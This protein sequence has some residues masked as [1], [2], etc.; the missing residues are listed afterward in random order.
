MERRKLIL[1]GLVVGLLGAALVMFGNPKNMGVCVVCFVRDIA[2]SFGL[3]RAAVVMR[4]RL[5]V[6]GFILGAFLA[7]LV[8]RE[9]KPRGG[10]SP[11]L[12]FFMG[13]MV[14]IAAL[15]FLGCPLRMVLRLA[16]GDLNALVALA[17]FTVGI[18]L[19]IYFLRRGFTL[20]RS[21]AQTRVAAYAAPASAIGIILLA[22]IG[23][24]FLLIS[25]SGPGASAAPLLIALGAGLLVGLVAQRTRLCMVGGIRDIILFRDTQLISG[26][27]GVFL[28]ALVLNIATGSFSLGFLDQPVAHNNH[29]YNFFGMAVVGLGASLLGGC[30]L[31]QF[32]LAGEGD[33]DA[34]T[35]CLGLTVGAA[36]AHNWGLA[37]SP[38]GVPDNGRIAGWI[39]LGIFLLIGWGALE[40]IKTTRVTTSSKEVKM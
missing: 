29:F 12:R 23:P 7:S 13:A 11:V 15:L 28:A 25:E 32:I 31:R 24:A 37:A 14:S 33:V 27:I 1:A 35:T 9:F 40:T 19:G 21:Y 26:F 22:V 39:I 10:S 5:E 36:I 38:A 4:L 30:P 16:N 6:P 17:G 3:H 20:G 18:V 8:A 34:M 2:G